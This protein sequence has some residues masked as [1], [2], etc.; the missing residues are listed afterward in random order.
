MSPV[1]VAVAVYVLAVV[2]GLVVYV[3]TKDAL[4]DLY[5]RLLWWY[6]EHHPRTRQGGYR[7]GRPS[8]HRLGIAWRRRWSSLR[9]HILRSRRAYGSGAARAFFVTRRVFALRSET[10][11]ARRVPWALGV[12]A[13][14][15]VAAAG[16]T[17][18]LA[19]NDFGSN[20]RNAAAAGASGSRLA[21]GP[22]GAW[23]P[24][25]PAAVSHSA[26]AHARPHRQAR[27]TRTTPASHGRTQTRVLQTSLVS[28][29]TSAASAVGATTAQGT[30]PSPLQAPKGASAPSPLRAP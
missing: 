4:A 18:V 15:V 5:E 26:P 24:R 8:L 19:T 2:A 20:H 30:G 7:S 23:L 1:A 11:S 29:R 25:L 17:A 28:E 6:A 10:D 12:L 3:Q 22:L 16:L 27:P 13:G 9:A 14:V 21:L